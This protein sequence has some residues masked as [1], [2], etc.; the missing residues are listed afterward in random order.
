MS[1]VAIKRETTSQQVAEVLRRRI[2]S[3]ELA[4]GQGIRQEAIAQELGVSRL[5]V[6]EALV[7][8]EMQGLVTNAKYK[9]AVVASLSSDE[10]EEIYALRGLLESF[11]LE[12]AI[13]HIDE[14][15]LQQAEAILEQSRDVESIE[16]WVE[17]NWQFHRTL[18]Q[19]S[20]MQ[21]AL[22]TLEQILARSDR[23]FRLQRSMSEHLKDTNEE[24]HRNIIALLR[25]GD[26][27]AVVVAMREH[28][29]W[30]QQDL[31]STV[32]SLRADAPAKVEA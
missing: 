11:L 26:A 7:L 2:L 10:I 6:R 29:G 1:R 28:I 3:G 27:R 4:E 30:N 17:L 31:V 22:K 32:R 18:Y 19:A 24:Q 16:H 20:G 25:A 13:P 8:L 9:G 21:L 12:K 15:T 5:P 14:A 23:Y